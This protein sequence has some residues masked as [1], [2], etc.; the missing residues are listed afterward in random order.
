MFSTFLKCGLNDQLPT[1]IPVKL[2]KPSTQISRIL[3]I[4]LEVICKHKL[5]TSCVFLKTNLAAINYIS[6]FLF[7][8][9][10]ESHHYVK[11]FSHEE[12][13]STCILFIEILLTKCVSYIRRQGPHITIQTIL[14]PCTF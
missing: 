13:T 3:G 12:Y 8:D 9:A 6:I 10:T 5:Q 1:S 7:R 11:I 4:K 14:Q 2:L